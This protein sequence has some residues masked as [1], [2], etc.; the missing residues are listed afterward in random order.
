MGHILN[1]LFFFVFGQSIIEIAASLKNIGPIGD[2]QVYEYDASGM[3]YYIGSLLTHNTPCYTPCGA[4][5]HWNLG[6]ESSLVKKGLINP[7]WEKWTEI[8]SLLLKKKKLELN[9]S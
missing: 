2:F 4:L 3:F 1:W 5:I 8:P 9:P 6:Q 7:Y